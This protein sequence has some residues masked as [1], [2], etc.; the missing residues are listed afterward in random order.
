MY[1][2]A[3]SVKG[4]AS[5]TTYALFMSHHGWVGGRGGEVVWGDFP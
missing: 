5:R 4:D 2:A 3:V 1:R